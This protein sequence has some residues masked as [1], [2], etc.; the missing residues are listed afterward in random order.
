MKWEL[1][2]LSKNKKVTDRSIITNK[3]I[4][5]QAI[6]IKYELN[7]LNKLKKF[8]NAPTNLINFLNMHINRIKNN[9]DNI[10]NKQNKLINKVYIE[11]N[12]ANSITKKSHIK[13]FNDIP[14]KVKSINNTHVDHDKHNMLKQIKQVIKVHTKTNNAFINLDECKKA[15]K[16]L[17]INVLNQ[18]K[19][20]NNV[21]IQKSAAHKDSSANIINEV[22]IRD[23]NNDV[24]L[25][26]HILYHASKINNMH[27]CINNNQKNI[28][29]TLSNIYYDDIDTQFNKL[30]EVNEKL[31][32]L[33][34]STS[35]II[36]NKKLVKEQI[37]L[38]AKV[39]INIRKYTPIIDNKRAY[40]LEIDVYLSKNIDNFHNNVKNK[41]YHEVLTML[42]LIRKHIIKSINRMYTHSKNKKDNNT[43]K[44]VTS[45]NNANKKVPGTNNTNKKVPS[46]NNAN[47]KVT[48]TNKKVTNTNNAN[49]KITNANNASKKVT[50]INNFNKKVINAN[51]KPTN[52][53]VSNDTDRIFDDILLEI[54]NTIRS[55]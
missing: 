8:T 32:S 14:E 5:K 41:K 46:T 18:L 29:S 4:N 50:S 30:K 49:K 28:A 37:I 9:N 26:N 12:S 11:N 17:F 27:K 15:H 55:I 51:K 22:H 1:N 24:L 19:S 35:K 31:N 45:A 25:H 44:N 53:N 3:K 34:N 40:I 13:V 2:M 16:K 36:F 6:S 7:S 10:K 39:S 54:E 47:K 48:I 43:N 42:L 38:D 20:N 21:H 23:I 33:L 52:N